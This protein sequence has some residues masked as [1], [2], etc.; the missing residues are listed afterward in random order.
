MPQTDQS[1]HTHKHAPRTVLIAAELSRWTAQATGFGPC[2]RREHTVTLSVAALSICQVYDTVTLLALWDCHHELIAE[3]VKGGGSAE[4]NPL[5]NCHLACFLTLSSSLDSKMR[6]KKSSAALSLLYNTFTLPAFWH[7]RHQLTAECVTAGGS[8]ALN[9]WLQR[10]ASIKS[11]PYLRD[12]QCWLVSSAN[13]LIA[14]RLTRKPCKQG[15]RA[16]W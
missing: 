11:T 5:Y 12:V 15:S 2:K 4:F 7:C 13:Y 16:D 14:E 6:D 8:A 3:C 1:K 9:L 10:W